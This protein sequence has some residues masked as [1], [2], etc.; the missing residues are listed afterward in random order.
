MKVLITGAKGQLGRGLIATAPSTVDLHPVTRDDCD[1]AD[2]SAIAALIQQVA[3]DLVINAAAYTA[4]DKAERDE[5]AARA[6]RNTGGPGGG[7]RK[8]H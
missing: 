4:V 7:V 6:R 1:L 3:P 5:D 2:A 8:W